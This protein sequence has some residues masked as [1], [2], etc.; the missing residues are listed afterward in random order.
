MPIPAR[1]ATAALTLTF[2]LLACNDSVSPEATAAQAPRA[3]VAASTG[4]DHALVNGQGIQ[5][6]DALP[7]FAP[8]AKL[9]VVEGNPL[10]PGKVWT[11]RLLLPDGYVVNPHWH[12]TDENVTVLSGTLLF[13]FGQHYDESG[14]TAY[15]K[16]GFF[17]APAGESHYV[18]ARGRTEI[19]VHGLGPFALI[20]VEQTHGA[21]PDCSVP[22]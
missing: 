2:A 10:A 11:V 20:Y 12:P 5:W 4:G 22:S 6:G 3:D 17:T 14:M 1:A 9:A 8:G 16:D 18:R 21:L 7:C 13:G 15:G 19:Q